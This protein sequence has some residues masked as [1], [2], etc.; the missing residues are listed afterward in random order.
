MKIKFILLIFTFAIIAASCFRNKTE[1]LAVRK[2]QTH[3]EAMDTLQVAAAD[4]ENYVPK[5]LIIND[6]SADS[7][8]NILSKYDLSTLFKDYEGNYLVPNNGFYGKSF[9][10]IEMYFSDV[11]KDSLNPAVY[12]LK[13]KSRFKNNILPFEG[14]FTVESL[15]AFTDPN[16]DIE[17]LENW[18]LKNAFSLK[19]TFKIDEDKSRDG[20]GFY[21]GK[22]TTDFGVNKD[23][24]AEIWYYSQTPN[25]MGAGY[26]FDGNWTSYKTGKVNYAMWASDL[27]M[28]AN[29]ILK[30]FSI[31]ERD[32]EINKKYRHLGWENFWENEEWWN[33]D[34]KETL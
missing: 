27:F 17:A 28:I 20:S 33:E 2:N 18:G 12:H 23:D 11:Q 19:G 10:R 31:G 13:G 3:K 22:F 4:E 6:L 32:I 24:R 8:K 14:S 1:K 34:K 21:Q 15:V 26:Q 25:T 16:L 9:Y 29:G 7:T 30:D 5:P